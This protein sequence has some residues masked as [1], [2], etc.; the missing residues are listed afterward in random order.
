MKVGNSSMI[1]GTVK[2]QDTGKKIL[3][4]TAA[5]RFYSSD[6]TVATVDANG[7][8]IANKAGTCTIYVLSINGVRTSVKVTVTK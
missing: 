8:I 1:Q 5:L 3:S 6:N 7:R 2:G 4:H